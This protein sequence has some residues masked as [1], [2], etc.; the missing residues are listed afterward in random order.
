MKFSVGDLVRLK[1]PAAIPDGPLGV[2]IVL[3][4]R[5]IEHAKHGYVYHIVSVQFGSVARDLPEDD[6]E[7]LSKITKQKID[8]DP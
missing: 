6:F 3:D 1:R 2:G 8:N 4:S 5:P 7:L